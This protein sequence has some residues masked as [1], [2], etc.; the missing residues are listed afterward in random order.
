M[1]A[2]NAY[3][4]IYIYIFIR[5]RVRARAHSGSC[6]LMAERRFVYAS[7]DSSLSV[8]SSVCWAGW[9]LALQKLITTKLGL[10]AG[11]SAMFSFLC[12]TAAPPSSLLVRFIR[13][14]LSTH[15]NHPPPTPLGTATRIAILGSAT[16]PMR[17]PVF[18][19]EKNI[20]SLLK[21]CAGDTD[22]RQVCEK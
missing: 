17:N 21:G 19:N 8:F 18:L 11:E 16:L 22:T 3:I 1:F 4:Q 7:L 13:G 9:T 20:G 5:L 14:R 12:T 6:S 10:L 2:S 15:L